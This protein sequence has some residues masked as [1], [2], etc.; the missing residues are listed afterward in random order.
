MDPEMRI[1][2][3]FYYSLFA[4]TGRGLL[5]ETFGDPDPFSLPAS[6]IVERILAA[7]YTPDLEHEQRL[8]FPV[9]DNMAVVNRKGHTFVV[10]IEPEAETIAVQEH[11]DDAYKRGSDPLHWPGH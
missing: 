4:G 2:P 1:E 3:P 6:V 7:G 10:S 8:P 9:A 5:A 11:R